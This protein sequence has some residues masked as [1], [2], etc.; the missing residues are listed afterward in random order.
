MVFF[1]L[2]AATPLANVA[3]GN[4]IKA[5]VVEGNSKT[6]DSTVILISGLKVGDQFAFDEVDAVT[7]KLVD[8]GLFK[9]VNVQYTNF[10]GGLKIIIMAED[11][12]SWVVAP[13]YYN[14]PTNKGGGIGFGENNLFG[15]NKKLLLYGQY[16]TGDTF[17]VGGY[18]DPSI[19]GSR[20]TWQGDVYLLRERSI[21]YASPDEFFDNPKPVRESKLNYLNFGVRGGVNL[22]SGLTLNV[23][24]RGAKVFYDDTV[25]APDTDIVEVTGDP[26]SDPLDVPEP[27]MEG[28]M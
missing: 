8:S 26:T 5:I 11:K 21:E 2:G 27:G 7:A 4:E 1:I 15:E 25:L 6:R 16:A 24:L 19:A 3:F 17:F 13:T 18:I 10:N 28:S 9:N 12:H 23:R 20:F 22:F 14:Q